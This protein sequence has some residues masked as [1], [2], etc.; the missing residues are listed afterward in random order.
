MRNH[1]ASSIE[2]QPQTSKH[3]IRHRFWLWRVRPAR[4]YCTFSIHVSQSRTL[5]QLA[6]QH[7]VQWRSPSAWKVFR[8]FLTMALE[9]SIN[10]ALG[11]ARD[12]TSA[13]RS[14]PE[15]PG[16]TELSQSLLENPPKLSWMIMNGRHSIQSCK[17]V[18]QIHEVLPRLVGNL[19]IDGQS[20]LDHSLRI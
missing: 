18:C 12:G 10:G 16:R 17:G 1:S 13:C 2:I 9:A 6:G 5:T 19:A 15:D 7:S 8:Y 14:G 20:V 3:P 11:G 4:N